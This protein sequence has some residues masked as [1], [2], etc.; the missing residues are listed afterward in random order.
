MSHYYIYMKFLLSQDDEITKLNGQMKD[1]EEE[2]ARL[3]KTTNIQ[4]TQIDKHKSL[5]EE[6]AKKCNGLQLQVSAL[7]KVRLTIQMLDQQADLDKNSLY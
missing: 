7:Q 4:Q 3:Q 1:L 2:R 6:S 5:A